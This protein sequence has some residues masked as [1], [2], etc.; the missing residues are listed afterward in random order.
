MREA[1]VQLLTQAG[2]RLLNED[3]YAV[4]AKPG[5]ANY[6]TDADRHTQAFLRERLEALCPGSR[7]IGE[8]QANEPLTDAPTWV[9]DPIDGTTNFIH[10]YRCS[11]ISAA[12]LVNRKPA[13]GC[14][15]Q[16]YTREAFSAEAGGGAFL[17][18][19]PI[20]VSQYPLEKA[21][22]GFGTSPYNPELFHPTLDAARR[23]L[24]RAADLRRCGSAA[25]DLCYVASGRQD[26][27]FELILRPWDV[28]AGA[29]LVTEAGGAFEMPLLERVDF[30]R[31]STIL[32]ANAACADGFRR[33]LMDA[34]A[35]SGVDRAFIE[36]FE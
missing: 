20:H 24:E 2:A 9:V 26:A 30:N 1:L 7:F 14:V 31:S 35:E 15:Y 18:G 4:T 11:A 5:H 23:L 32:A 29:L 16:P 28:A 36:R 34:L 33:A 3:G 19:E 6:V 8:E 22:V 25:L 10:G 17:N 27:F 13:L 21:L 12:L